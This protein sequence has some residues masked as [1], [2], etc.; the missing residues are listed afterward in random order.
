LGV[1]IAYELCDAPYHR[2]PREDEMSSTGMKSMRRTIVHGTVLLLPALTVVAA[3]NTASA[4]PRAAA[5]PVSGSAVHYFTTAIVHSQEQNETGTIQKSTEIIQL[6][7]DL[8]GYIL[9]H[10]VST[11][12]LAS[13]TL[14]NTGTQFYSGT[15]L[16]SDPVILHDDTFR[17]TVDLATGE[18]I[19]EVR[20]SRSN[21]A[22]HRGAW[23]ECHLVVTGTGM[24]PAGDGMADYTGECLQRGN[25]N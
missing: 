24:T 9:Y 1:R 21:D 23:F 11:I 25:M 15:V 2:R 22:P 14:V 19:G 5:I 20:L 16:G 6:T 12:D 17:F 3:C 8:S 7:G 13:G 4:V 10:P 18:T